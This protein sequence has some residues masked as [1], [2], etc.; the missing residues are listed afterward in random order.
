MFTASHDV[1]PV[2]AQA[3]AAHRRQMSPGPEREEEL[4]HSPFQSG[5]PRLS[6]GVQREAAP[7]QPGDDAPLPSRIWQDMPQTELPPSPGAGRQLPAPMNCFAKTS[8]GGAAEQ[9]TSCCCCRI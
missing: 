2:Q 6:P 4:G 3:F 8:P 9:V 5:R 7:K 1:V